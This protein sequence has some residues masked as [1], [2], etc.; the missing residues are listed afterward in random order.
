L[1]LAEGRPLA[2]AQAVAGHV[3]VSDAITADGYWLWT[4]HAGAPPFSLQKL[5]DLLFR[6]TAELPR[7]V[8]RDAVINACNAVFR[9]TKGALLQF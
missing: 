1:L 2:L 7:D 9:H 3:I 4:L 6:Q 5:D 8:G